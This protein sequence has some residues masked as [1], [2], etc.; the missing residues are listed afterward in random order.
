MSAICGLL[1]LDGSPA[2]RERLDAMTTAAVLLRPDA[3]RAAVL[4]PAALAER[5]PVRSGDAGAPPDRTGVG[6]S[7]VAVLDGRID[8]R[9][10]ILAA[11]PDVAGN[12]G[13][14]E[15][16]AA[17]YRAWGEGLLQRLIGDFALAVWDLQARRLLCARDPAGI[18][19]FYYW[20][21]PGELSFAS[22]L[23]QLLTAAEAPAFDDEYFGLFLLDG[24]PALAATPYQGIRR[25]PPGHCLIAED[26]RVRVERWWRPESL[27]PILYRDDDE[28]AA[29]FREVFAQ[30]VR[31]HL[32]ADGPVW[33]E[34]SGGLDSS[35]IVAVAQR[36]FRAGEARDRGFATATMVFATTG[37][38]DDPRYRQSLIERDGFPAHTIT[39]DENNVFA[40]MPAGVAFWDEPHQQVRFYAF[41][42]R[43]Q[44]MLEEAGV[45][46][47]LC[48]NGGEI[49]VL[50]E[51]P[52]PLHLADLLRQGRWGTAWREA[53]IWQRALRLPLANVMWVWGVSPLLRPP[54]R[55]Y[56]FE[57]AVLPAWIEP[58]FARRLGLAR[59]ANRAIMPPAFHGVGDQW[60][61]EKLGRSCEALFRGYM[62]YGCEMRYPF[63]ARPVLEFGFAVPYRRL[64]APGTFKPVLRRA[65]AGILPETIRTRVDKGDIGRWVVRSLAAQW[66]A[67]EPLLRNSVLAELGYV[68]GEELHRAVHMF[69]Y[70]KAQRTGLLSAIVALEI[71]TRWALGAS[72]F[73]SPRQPADR[74]AEVAVV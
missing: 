38:G 39:A 70:G 11:L 29:H 12:A 71:W 49:P 37:P 72:P 60:Q 26:G 33:S 41:F 27:A 16:L 25:L 51:Y 10:E 74:H 54:N 6:S 34:L 35:S 58:A 59:R 8:N 4:G 63:L 15:L 66:P 67:L 42:R 2:D 23:R 47:L 62:E 14:A 56:A 64:L 46:A 1:R 55:S 22:Q 61:Y 69:T 40:D 31:A 53:L 19:R 28:Y 24:A 21:R 44:R 3:A 52:P 57:K 17:A 68:R 43:Y 5:G 65:M 48:G 32:R 45:S 9:E 18:R 20:H 13:D 50:T 36:L 7:P 73:A 30:A